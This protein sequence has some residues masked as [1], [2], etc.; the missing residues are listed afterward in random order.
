M[1]GHMT[2][3]SLLC[4]TLK[5][6]DVVCGSDYSNLDLQC[7]LKVHMLKVLSLRWQSL[8]E[9]GS[10]EWS[11]VY[12]EYDFEEVALLHSVLSVVAICILTRYTE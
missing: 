3:D 2:S 4:C 7:L 1:F 11:S 6:S 12:L 10:S 5:E 8:Q 9:V